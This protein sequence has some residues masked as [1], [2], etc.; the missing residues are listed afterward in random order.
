MSID[1]DSIRWDGWGAAAQA[2]AFPEHRKRFLIAELERRFGRRLETSGTGVAIDRVELPSSRLSNSVRSAL[3][4]ICGES[5][6]RTD[7]RDRIVHSLGRSLPDLLRLRSGDIGSAPDAVVYPENAEQVASVLRIAGD[8]NFA[9]VPFGGGTSVVGGVEARAEATHTGVITLD[10]T[11]MSEL[12]RVDPVNRTAVLQA[13]I[14]GPGLERALGAHGYT[15]GHFP[16]SFEY[17]TLGGW[18]ATRSTGQSSSGYGAIDDM[19]VALRIVTPRGEIR[20]LEVPRSAAGPDLNEWILGSEGTLGVITEATM[21]VR[22]APSSTDDRGM[23][24]RSFSDGVSTIRAAVGEGVRVSMM[25]L[26]DASEVELL[27]ILRRD[28][29][30][31]IDPTRWVWRATERLG[32]GAE[33]TLLIYS[34][35]G[36]E[37]RSVRRAVRRARAVGRAFG[38]LPLGRS[39]GR[40]WRRE[41]FRGPYLRDWLLD[42]GVAVDT[43]ETA[44]EWSRVESAHRSILAALRQ[45]AATHAGSGLA[46]THLSHSYS[47]G[48][49]LYFTLLYP[50]DAGAGLNQWRKIKRDVTDSIVASGGT[51]SHHHGVGRDHADWFDEE[52]GALAVEALRSAKAVVDPT[53][54]MNP[55]K[56]L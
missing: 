29:A 48:A 13:G 40:G 31:R 8:A 34:A 54:I 25:R 9:V 4:S 32:Y 10:T 11:R 37:A 33:S 27:R 39:P 51:L 18:I 14:D 19:L 1:R 36:G 7:L 52:K 46:M 47:D 43:Y 50:L 21:R 17:S 55:G 20:T 24:F 44:V 28:P 30:R 26:S 12:L 2:N 16:Q 23:L 49:C 15:L 56:L 41:R 42:Y 3:E 35:E 38:G 6:V 45:A 5:G 53:G 22:P